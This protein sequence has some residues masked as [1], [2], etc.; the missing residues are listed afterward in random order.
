MFHCS[1]L[2]VYC[3]LPGSPHP[4]GPS[5]T[6]AKLSVTCPTVAD[7]NRWQRRRSRRRRQRRKLRG[8]E[9][10]RTLQSHAPT[11]AG[12]ILPHPRWLAGLCRVQM[13][14]T[15]RVCI[16]ASVVHSDRHVVALLCTQG[17]HGGQGRSRLPRTTHTA[18][19]KAQL[20]AMGSGESGAAAY[21]SAS[22]T[23]C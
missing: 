1:L 12:N 16:G 19:S 22:E 4:E 8:N 23:C 9:P 18:Q 2:A 11:I 17:A 20:K 5:T 10:L 21:L 3:H 14:G 13:R 7:W 15:D 6:Q